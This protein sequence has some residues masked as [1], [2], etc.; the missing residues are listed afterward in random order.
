MIKND[1]MLWKDIFIKVIF[2]MIVLDF[3][4]F[5]NKYEM[6]KLNFYGR[7]LVELLYVIKIVLLRMVFT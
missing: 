1:S 5:K 2:M 4:F 7:V 6:L 3:S